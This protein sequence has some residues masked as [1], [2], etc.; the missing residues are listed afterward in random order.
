MGPSRLPSGIIPPVQ[1]EFVI[2][3]QP[4]MGD[5]WHLGPWSI[6]GPNNDRLAKLSFDKT[7]RTP[8]CYL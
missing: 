1:L 6:C 3:P 2:S 4:C 5:L 7:Q 8:V